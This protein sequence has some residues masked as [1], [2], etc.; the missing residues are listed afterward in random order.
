MP[1]LSVDDIA[2]REPS[3][4]MLNITDLMR[5]GQAIGGVV[6]DGVSAGELNKPNICYLKQN[7]FLEILRRVEN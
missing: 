3:P 4:G 6:G 7:R 5:G 2:R 1:W